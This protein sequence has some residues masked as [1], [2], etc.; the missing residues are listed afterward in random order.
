AEARRRAELLLAGLEGET[1]CGLYSGVAGI[2]F[3]LSRAFEATQDA[4]YDHGARRCVR[5]LEER[6]TRA[7]AGVEWPGQGNDVEGGAAGI[8]LFLLGA[9]GGQD[10]AQGAARRLVEL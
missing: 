8:G 1:D 4:R 7:G 2:G 6:A 10:L 9:P 5:L 3:A